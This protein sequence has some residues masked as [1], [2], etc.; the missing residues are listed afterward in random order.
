MIN[1]YYYTTSFMPV[2]QVQGCVAL[3]PIPS[4]ISELSFIDHMVMIWNTDGA[5]VLRK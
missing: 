1:T 2:S 4:Y 5:Q 3:I